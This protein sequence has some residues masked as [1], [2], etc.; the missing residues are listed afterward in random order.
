[1]A[2]PHCHWFVSAYYTTIL[3]A[4]VLHAHV[5]LRKFDRS[6][7]SFIDSIVDVPVI[8]GFAKF[9]DASVNSNNQFICIIYRMAYASIMRHNLKPGALLGSARSRSEFQ[10]I[11]IMHSSTRFHFIFSIEINALCHCLTNY[12]KRKRALHMA[13]AHNMHIAHIV[14][15][16]VS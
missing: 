3:L 13:V 12:H 8:P 15:W 4:H 6:T 1:M 14:S 11:I 5:A 7:P 16:V 9:F 2:K 10:I